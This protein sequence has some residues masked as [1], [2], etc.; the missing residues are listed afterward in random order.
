MMM[1]KT[2]LAA[3]VALALGVTACS[4]GDDKDN[5]GT[6][7]FNAAD[8]SIVNQSAKTGGTLNLALSD[9]WD[10][11]D[12]GNTYYAFS[13]NFA[14]LYGRALTTFKP[15]AGK[16]GLTLVPD[17]AQNLGEVSDGGRTVTYKLKPGI[18]Y[19][20]GTP[21]TA[22]DVK[23]AVARTYAR[24]VLPNGPTYFVDLLDAGTYTGPYKNT[25]INAF[26]GIQTPDDTTVVFKLK[27]PFGDFDFLVS[28]PQTIPVP[29]AKDTGAKYQEHPMSTGSYKVDTYEPGKQFVLSKN[30]NWDSS[31]PNRKQLVDKID[32]KLKVN[33]EDI[34]NRLLAG[35]LDADIAGSGM[36]AA[37][38]SR[39]L[40]DPN[41]KK[42]S[43]NTFTGRL[44][45][46]VMDEKVAPFDNI[47]CRKAV[48]YA[49]DKVALQ[50]A[51]GG[52]IAGGD[53]ATT[54]LPPTIVGYQK[55]DL[56][57]TPES[58][59]DVAKAKDAL[60]R[61][62]RPDG[63]ETKILLRADRP[64][65]VAAGEALQQA[66]GKVNIKAEIRSVPAGQYFTRFAGAP[67]YMK[68]NQ[69]GI[70]FHGWQADW[71]TGYGFLQQL[72]DGRTIKAQGNTNVQEMN[73]P[74]I[75][76]MF[77]KAAAS[78]DAKERETIYGQ[79]DKAAMEHASVVPF[80]Y[81]KGLLYRNPAM[82]N[83]FISYPFGMYDYVGLGK[84]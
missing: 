80:L 13:W 5:G 52:P 21:V 47:E 78:T 84:G 16:D 70:A 59:G 31:D 67:E 63:F 22:K 20:D 28:S 40:S 58:K 72:V 61:C 7:E 23:Y 73:V 54:M 79:I 9:D 62:G 69:I 32:V 6:A 81:G 36:Q 64:N 14:R 51:Y 34:D 66:L 57:A 24:D 27:Q 1:K 18:K 50:T 77:D 42:N 37:A 82:T 68:G 46:F 55:F 39:V 44:W 12:P 60:T 15:A 2:G 3:V 75:N 19:E 74:E 10:S 11:I 83:V 41:L 48:Q 49:T 30:P 29:Q 17:L 56:Y 25:D 35:S 65:E 33:A 26:T 71:P 45:F 8:A 4:S 76:A 53:V 38:R 43:D